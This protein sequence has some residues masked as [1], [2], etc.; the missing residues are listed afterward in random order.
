MSG[1]TTSARARCR[2]SVE[3]VRGCRPSGVAGGAIAR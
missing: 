3:R 2:L 1:R